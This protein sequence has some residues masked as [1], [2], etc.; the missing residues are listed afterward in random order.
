MSNHLMILPLLRISLCLIL[1][2]YTRMLNNYISINR[3]GDVESKRSKACCNS[4]VP[5]LELAGDKS[6]GNGKSLPISTNDISRL[7]LSTGP[8]FQA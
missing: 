8:E 1:L 6:T 5:S 2:S 7:V 4:E 3:G